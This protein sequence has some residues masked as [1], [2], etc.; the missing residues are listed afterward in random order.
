MSTIISSIR[1]ESIQLKLPK[2]SNN[3]RF[4]RQLEVCL[5]QGCASGSVD[6]PAGFWNWQPRISGEE[7]FYTCPVNLFLFLSSQEVVKETIHRFERS[8]QL[9]NAL[10]LFSSNERA[11]DVQTSHL[12]YFLTPAFLGFLTSRLTGGD[13]LEIVT[14]SSV[15]FRDFLKRLYEYQLSSSPPPEE[16]RSETD[17]KQ[18]ANTLTSPPSL[19]EMAV[20]RGEKI[21]KFNE[22]QKLDQDLDKMAYV[23]KDD[24]EDQLDDELVRNYWLTLIRRWVNIALDEIK[25]LRLEKQMLHMFA[26]KSLQDLRQKH[27]TSAARFK[28]FIITKNE[29][30]KQVYGLG[31]PSRP[32]VTIEEF[33]NT[34][35]EEGSLSVAPPQG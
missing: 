28:P 16:E 24:K 22:N 27:K 2:Q 32:T 25:S 19:E 30:Q 4:G 3:G 18:D 35:I 21:R 12:K 31:Y 9:I 23:L 11:D 5:P 29:L 17:D 8:T 26:G 1:F 13:R 20:E 7:L 14:L 15:Y 33:V 34:K 10:Q 6:G